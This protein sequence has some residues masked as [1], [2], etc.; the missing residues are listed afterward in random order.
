MGGFGLFW[1]DPARRSGGRRDRDA[2]PPGGLRVRVG[3]HALVLEAVDHRAGGNLPPALRQPGIAHQ[4]DGAGAQV[5][6]DPAGTAL[7]H[8]RG[9]T[10]ARGRA[11]LLE[12]GRAAGDDGAGELVLE[13]VDGGVVADQRAVRGADAHAAAEGPAAVVEVQAGGQRLGGLHAQHALRE[14]DL[15]EAQRVV[16]VVEV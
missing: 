10:G 9:L 3:Q 1:V 11:A 14:L 7:H 6:L 8:A 15:A 13:E 5:V 12:S 2:D 4:P 16:L